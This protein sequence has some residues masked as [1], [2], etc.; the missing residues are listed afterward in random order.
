MVAGFTAL[1]MSPS[2]QEQNIQTPLAERWMRTEGELRSSLL[3][4]SF[5]TRSEFTTSV[6]L[7]DNQEQNPLT[8]LTG[9]FGERL[10]RIKGDLKDSLLVHCLQNALMVRSRD[11]LPRVT[12]S[13]GK[14]RFDQVQ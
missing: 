2:Y 1:V 11:D 14:V 12:L 10:L 3:V 13:K 6:V 8:P 7:F 5:K 4:D 9:H